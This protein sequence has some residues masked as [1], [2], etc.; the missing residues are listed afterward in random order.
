MSQERTDTLTRTETRTKKAPM[1]K[2]LL[3]NDD[4]TTWD[5]VVFV[6]MRF[7]P[8]KLPKPKLIRLSVP[9]SKKGIRLGQRWSQNKNYEVGNQDVRLSANSKSNNLIS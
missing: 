1:F 4:Y 9:H 8:L 5:F 2:V 3:L 6:L 7:T